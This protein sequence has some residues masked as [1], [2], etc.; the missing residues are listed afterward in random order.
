[1]NVGAS[2]RP[3]LLLILEH[4]SMQIF[5]HITEEASRAIG[6]AVLLMLLAAV[7]LIVALIWG[8][9]LLVRSSKRKRDGKSNADDT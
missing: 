3:P 1:M 4:T 7:T 8:I 6:I 5:A 9:V 2:Q